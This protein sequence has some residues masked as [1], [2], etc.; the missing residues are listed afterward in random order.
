MTADDWQEW[1]A[2]HTGR[3]VDCDGTP[4]P[5]TNFMARAEIGETTGPYVKTGP[6]QW[7]RQ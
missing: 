7:S 1:L 5:E 3:T 6:D 2:E 4:Q